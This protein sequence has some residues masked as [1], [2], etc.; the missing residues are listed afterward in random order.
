MEM[1]EGDLHPCTFPRFRWTRNPEQA[2]TRSRFG[3]KK[4]KLNL[5]SQRHRPAWISQ[6]RGRFGRTP[7]YDW[8]SYI[9]ASLYHGLDTAVM[10]RGGISRFSQLLEYWFYEYCGVGHPIVKE[11]LKITSYSHLKAWE[12]G[13]RKKTNNQAGNLFTI[14]RYFIDHRI[15]GSIN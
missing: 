7:E 11:V 2:V 10:T 13:N 12:K 15:I 4:K 14:V 6:G 1:P 9:L 5:N 8:G 3:R